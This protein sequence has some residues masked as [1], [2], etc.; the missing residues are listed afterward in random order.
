MFSEDWVDVDYYDNRSKIM[1]HYPN[2]FSHIFKPRSRS[3]HSCW[4]DEYDYVNDYVVQPVHFEDGTSV[5]ERMFICFTKD[6]KM[7][8]LRLYYV[9]QEYNVVESMPHS[10][11]IAG[12][13]IFGFHEH[14]P[15]LSVLML[16]EESA[17]IK[18]RVANKGRVVELNYLKFR[19]R[20]QPSK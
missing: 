10:S 6:R 9:S 4:G 13:F 15:L 14:N 19:E 17:I 12:R 11:P 18:R 20:K 3:H 2:A 7:G 16:A 1:T 5:N 8:N